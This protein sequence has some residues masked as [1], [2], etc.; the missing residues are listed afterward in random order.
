VSIALDEDLDELARVA[1]ARQGLEACDWPQLRRAILEAGGIGPSPDWDGSESWPGDLYRVH[2]KKPDLAAVEIT[3]GGAD[4]PPWGDDR[5]IGDDAMHAYLWR[6]WTTFQRAQ[7][8]QQATVKHRATTT[9]TTTPARGTRSFAELVADLKRKHG[10]EVDLAGL[11]REYV[12]AYETGERIDVVVDGRTLR[13][14]V[15]ATRGPKP[16]F[17][18]LLSVDLP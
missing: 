3:L 10:A 5:G 14:T 16:R 7:E 8:A 6:S 18:L 17:V 15:G 1:Y 9:T 4:V 12:R 13:G 2:G 11:R